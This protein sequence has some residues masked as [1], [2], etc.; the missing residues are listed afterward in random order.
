MYDR[1]QITTTIKQQKAAV[2]YPKIL[3]CKCAS[4]WYREGTDILWNIWCT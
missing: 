4:L 2:T 3:V 1:W